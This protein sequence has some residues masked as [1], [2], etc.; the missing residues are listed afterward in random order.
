MGS[1]DGVVDT[2]SAW[3]GKHEVVEVRYRPDVLPYADLLAAAIEHKCT[4]R[5]WSTNDTQR[6]LASRVV[7]DRH[8]PYAGNARPAKDSDQ[9]YYLERSPYRFVPLTPLQARRVNGA[10]H[11]KTDPVRYLSRRQH[12]LAYEIEGRLLS[13]TDVLDGLRRPH[14]IEGLA[15]YEAELRER[16]DRQHH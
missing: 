4:H 2:R 6:R 10:L 5:V 7:P 13:K 8:E 15:K 1:L 3:I 11:A 14:R 12:E 16:L 9:L